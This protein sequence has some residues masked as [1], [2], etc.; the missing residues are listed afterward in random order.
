MQIW[1][2]AIVIIVCGGIGGF[3]NALNAGDLHLPHR[4]PGNVYSPG[5]IGNVIIGSV[6]AVVLWGLYGP[7]AKVVLI[8]ESAAAVHVSMTFADV[9]GAI[10]TGI[11]GARIL[12]NEVEKKAMSQTKK[13]LT[14]FTDSGEKK[15]GD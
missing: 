13:N 14:E 10:L 7:M 8:G 4:Q 6:A 15:H 2:I 9:A 11:G 3:A 1:T 5:W 12:S